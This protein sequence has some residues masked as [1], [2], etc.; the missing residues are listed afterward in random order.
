[1]IDNSTVILSRYGLCL[2]LEISTNCF[3]ISSVHETKPNDGS[4]EDKGHSPG[5]KSSSYNHHYVLS[6]TRPL[7][8]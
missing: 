3:N 5:I 4:L 6:D 2:L 1:M 8:H 7:S